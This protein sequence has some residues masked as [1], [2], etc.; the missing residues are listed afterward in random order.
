V[1]SSNDNAGCQITDPTN[2]PS[3]GVPFNKTGGGVFATGCTS[4]NIKIWFFPR[5]SIPADISASTP[6][7]S[8]WA[9]PNSRFENA[10][11]DLYSHFC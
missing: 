10:S 5:G 8:S 9:E 11:D 3:F 7:P 6:N 2:M 4:Q 1:S